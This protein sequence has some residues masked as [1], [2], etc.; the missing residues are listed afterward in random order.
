[1]TYIIFP[2]NH[3]H[4]PKCQ[5]LF[6]SFYHGR[7]YKAIK[8]HTQI[9]RS[10]NPYPKPH[11]PHLESHQPSRIS[12]TVID[13]WVPYQ[14]SQ[15]PRISSIPVSPMLQVSVPR[16]QIVKSEMDSKEGETAAATSEKRFDAGIKRLGPYPSSVPRLPS[17]SSLVPFS[18]FFSVPNRGRCVSLKIGLVR[19]ALWGHCLP[20]SLAT[21]TPTLLSLCIS[22]IYSPSAFP[23]R[24]APYDRLIRPLAR[25]Q[26]RRGGGINSCELMPC[27]WMQQETARWTRLAT[28]C[29]PSQIHPRRSHGAKNNL[30][31]PPIDVPSWKHDRNACT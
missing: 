21:T 31:C 7:Q 11:V 6:L 28:L 26:S 19:H 23:P 25:I 17:S 10:E 30:P 16:D 13:T 20:P 4:G 1:M 2:C 18:C 3:T 5:L 29:L 14:R 15:G 27:R 24:F 12:R 22:C 9:C 8:K